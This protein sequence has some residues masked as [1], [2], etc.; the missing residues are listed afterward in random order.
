MI[1]Y[2]NLLEDEEI[3]ALTAPFR[4]RITESRSVFL[5]TCPTMAPGSSSI[6]PVHMLPLVAW[7]MRC[8]HGIPNTAIIDEGVI[9]WTQ[10]GYPIEAGW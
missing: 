2:A 8:A 5:A 4:F 1:G 10:R 3:D 6:A 7:S 9:V